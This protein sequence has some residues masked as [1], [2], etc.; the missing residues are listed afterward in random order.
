LKK[1]RWK[2][3]P[4]AFSPSRTSRGAMT[5]AREPSTIMSSKLTMRPPRKNCR[6]S[7]RPRAAY[8]RMPA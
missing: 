8:G 4:G 5:A 7:W 6:K 1:W 3:T 2:A